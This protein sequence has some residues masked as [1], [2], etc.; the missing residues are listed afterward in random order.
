M[1]D[2]LD[3]KINPT[4]GGFTVLSAKGLFPLNHPQLNSVMIKA[5]VEQSLFTSIK[6]VVFALRLRCGHI[7]Q[8]QFNS[9]M[10]SERFYLGGANSI[11][12]YD[13][14]F[15]PPLGSFVKDADGKNKECVCF[16]PQGGKSMINVNAEVRFPIFKQLGGV[17]F[18]DLGA[19]SSNKF[20]DFNTR[21]IL[22]GTG[23]GL[24]FATPVGPLR[25]DIAWKWT[26]M[27]STI[28][29]YAWFLTFGQAF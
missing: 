22:A 15:A 18:Q 1:I 8:T 7:F 20:A 12:S 10:P 13:T 26:K 3:Q 4:R 2:L 28:R 21:S 25:F 9:I 19:L 27:P 16:V 17:L 23:A 29:S 11:R 24:R 14:D 6:S 5:L